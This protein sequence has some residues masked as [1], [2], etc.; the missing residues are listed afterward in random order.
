MRFWIVPSISSVNGEGTSWTTRSGWRRAA[1]SI[2]R[3]SATFMAMRASQRTCLPAS[4][5]ASVISQWRL[6]HVPMQMASVSLARTRSGHES[7]TR[8]MPNSRA[9]RSDDSRLRLAT[10]TMSIPGMAL[11]PG[12]CRTLVLLPAPTMPMRRGVVVMGLQNTSDRARSVATPGGEA[13]VPRASGQAEAPDSSL[14]VGDAIVLEG[15][16]DL[17]VFLVPVAD[18]GQRADLEAAV[19]QPPHAAIDERAGRRRLMLLALLGGRPA[20]LEHLATAGAP[21][22]DPGERVG[23]GNGAPPGEPAP[24]LHV[25]AAAEEAPDLLGEHERAHQVADDEQDDGNHD[26]PPGHRAAEIAELD[27]EGLGDGALARG[28]GKRDGL[29]AGADATGPP[30]GRGGVDVLDAQVVGIGERRQELRE[31]AGQAHHAVAP[32][33]VEGIEGQRSGAARA[34]AHQVATAPEQLLGPRRRL[35]RDHVLDRKSVG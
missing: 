18:G 7:Y 8:E 34:E 28:D 13:R 35:G 24:P 14:H 19:G 3:P 5:A 30:R 22:H 29:P 25:K 23:G 15:D 9:T 12:M 21:G 20:E 32:I 6:G 26:G 10:L 4:R 16:L 11:S 1:S 17:A 27:L 31:V 2:R 33:E